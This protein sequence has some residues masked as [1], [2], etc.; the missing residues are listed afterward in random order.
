MFYCGLATVSENSNEVEKDILKT[1]W[2]PQH[3]RIIYSVRKPHTYIYIMLSSDVWLCACVSMVHVCVHVCM[4]AYVCMPCPQ[5]CVLC[6]HMWVC[7][8]RNGKETSCISL[9]PKRHVLFL[10]VKWNHIWP[11]GRGSGEVSLCTW[12]PRERCKCRRTPPLTV[13]ASF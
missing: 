13:W 12:A 4:C 1:L 11:T 9:G 8:E 7:G 2:V 3:L 5:V 10:W 6:M